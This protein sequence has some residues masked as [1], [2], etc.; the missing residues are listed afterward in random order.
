MQWIVL[1]Q[2]GFWGHRRDIDEY[3]TIEDETVGEIESVVS[4]GASVDEAASRINSNRINSKTRLAP[5]LTKYMAE[6]RVQVRDGGWERRRRPLSP[7]LPGFCPSLLKMGGCP[8][9]TTFS[10]SRLD[11]HPSLRYVFIPAIVVH[12]IVEARFSPPERFIQV[13]INTSTTSW[14]LLR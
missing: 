3:F 11:L 5:D 7:P 1:L 8:L 14:Q 6:Y 12:Q 9:L 13:S 2:G 10:M 4:G